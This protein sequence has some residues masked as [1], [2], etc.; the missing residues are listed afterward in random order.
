MY[1]TRFWVA[2]AVVAVTVSLTAAPA[3]QPPAPA[4]AAAP[5]NPKLE[6]YKK[7]VAL[8]VDGMREDIQ[9]MNDQVFSFG[10]LGFQE[11]ETSKYLTGILKKNGFTIQEN[12]AGI[13]TAWMA[14]WGSGKPVIA[15]GS[16]VDCIPQASQ[17]PGVAWHD[18]IIDGAPGHG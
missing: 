1:R 7:D 15:L 3:Q 10:E 12:L 8:E 11:F 16:D 18:A 4:A 13:P 17:K 2:G 5:A 9:R 6:Q 14:T